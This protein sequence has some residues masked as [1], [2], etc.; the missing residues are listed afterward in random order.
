MRRHS[1]RRISFGREGIQGEAQ[2]PL[3]T[4]TLINL[5]GP[6]TEPAQAAAQAPTQTHLLAPGEDQYMSK[7]A[8]EKA[9]KRYREEE[10]RLAEINKQRVALEAV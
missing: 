7:E 1:N 10:E 3:L 5:N 4:P 2:G 9:N 8:I 6:P